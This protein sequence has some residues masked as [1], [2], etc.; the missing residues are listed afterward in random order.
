MGMGMTTALVGRMVTILRYWMLFW[1]TCSNS[2]GL[3]LQST[4][5]P[6]MTGPCTSMARFSTGAI[7]SGLR[8]HEPRGPERSAYL[9]G[10]TGPNATPD[11]RPYFCSSWTATMS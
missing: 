7:S 1:S 6:M 3:S 8:I 11:R 2:L 5:T 10:S 4:W 9:T